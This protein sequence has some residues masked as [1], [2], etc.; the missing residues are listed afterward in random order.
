MKVFLAS[1]SSRENMG[2]KELTKIPYILESFFTIKSE[3]T[4]NRIV[5]IDKEKF[6]LDS[7]AFTFMNSYKGKVDWDKYIDDYA[8][9]INKYD[10]KYFLN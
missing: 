10:I 2:E 1:T 7:G 5:K 3:K 6:L 4:L 8:N 9:F